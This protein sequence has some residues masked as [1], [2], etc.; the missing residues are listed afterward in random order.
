MNDKRDKLNLHLNFM[1]FQ[2]QLFNGVPG[3]VSGAGRN[4]HPPASVIGKIVAE[5]GAG[6]LVLSRFMPRSLECGDENLKQIRTRC[7]GPVV[8]ADDLACIKF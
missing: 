3:N 1:K 4:L 6:T 8:S 7:H 5:T 2:D